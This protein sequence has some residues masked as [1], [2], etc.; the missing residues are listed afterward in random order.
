MQWRGSHEA[1]DGRAVRVR[2]NSPLPQP[3]VRHGLGIDLRDHERHLGVHPEGGA[4]VHDDGTAG[5]DGDDAG[6]RRLATALRVEDGGVQH[7][8]SPAALLLQTPHTRGLVRV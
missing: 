6:V 3:D 5:D 2:H 8:R 7:H 1:D 4:V